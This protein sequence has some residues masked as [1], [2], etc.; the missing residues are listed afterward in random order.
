MTDI[1]Y[2]RIFVLTKKGK[3]VKGNEF[4][5]KIKKLGRKNNIFVEFIIQ[6]GKGSHGTLYYGEK[7]TIVRNSK[8]EL[9]TG[10]LHGMLNQLGLKLDD[11]SSL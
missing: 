4:I 6:R 7:F 3:V 1:L 8:D 9:K 11:L 2:K 10:T 5:R